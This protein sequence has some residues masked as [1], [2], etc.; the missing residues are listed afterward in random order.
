[1]ST[2]ASYSTSSG[3]V[4]L[5]LLRRIN[6][7][8]KDSPPSSDHVPDAHFSYFCVMFLLIY[9][10]YCP[11]YYINVQYNQS[12]PFLNGGCCGGCSRTFGPVCGPTDGRERYLRGSTADEPLQDLYIATEQPWCRQGSAARRQ[13]PVPLP[14]KPKRGGELFFPGCSVLTLLLFIRQLRLADT[15]QFYP[16]PETSGGT[17]AEHVGSALHAEG[18][19]WFGVVEER[20]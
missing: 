12:Q 19:S 6:C 14:I 7:S 10:R 16:R 3:P 1:M 11:H 5:L 17:R 18:V 15:R 13:G 8:H 2:S 4:Y 9:A 20:P